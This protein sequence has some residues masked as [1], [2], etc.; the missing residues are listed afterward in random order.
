MRSV[1]LISLLV[2]STTT[3]ALEHAFAQGA[4]ERTQI[5]RKPYPYVY[6]VEP[7]GQIKGQYG[8]GEFWDDL[9]FGD[10]LKQNP[11]LHE[12][13]LGIDG[14]GE[15]TPSEAGRASN[16]INGSLPCGMGGACAPGAGT[17]G[18]NG[19]NG[20]GPCRR[21]ICPP[22]VGLGGS[23]DFGSGLPLRDAL[24]IPRDYFSSPPNPGN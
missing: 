12:S 2:V 15:G 4:A 23:V 6:I 7:D 11:C 5:E 21:G 24:K 13:K 10:Q 17:G 1:A 20:T 19:G 9:E 14:C 16:K 8:L 3:F 22:S 18:G